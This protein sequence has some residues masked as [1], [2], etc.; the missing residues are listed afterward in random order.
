[1]NAGSHLCFFVDTSS[2]HQFD[3]PAELSSFAQQHRSQESSVDVPHRI[4]GRLV[5]LRHARQVIATQ[6]RDLEPVGGAVS[7][8]HHTPFQL[9]GCEKKKVDLRCLCHTDIHPLEKESYG[10]QESNDPVA[11]DCFDLYYSLCAHSDRA[12]PLQSMLFI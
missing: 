11:V 5:G 8:L 3:S 4:H 10:N 2:T 6:G 9:I 1:M 12:W 7:R